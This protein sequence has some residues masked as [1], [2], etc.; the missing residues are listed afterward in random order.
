MTDQEII[1]RGRRAE[2]LAGHTLL[3][4][5]LETLRQATITQWMGTEHVPSETAKREAC[6]ALLWAIGAFELQLHAFIDDAL[7]KKAAI[8]HEAKMAKVK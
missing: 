4:E 7:L 1:E 5:A 3:R 2:T 8:E 6:H